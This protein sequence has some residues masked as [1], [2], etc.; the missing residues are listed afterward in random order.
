[1]TITESPTISPTTDATVTDVPVETPTPA[2]RPRRGSPAWIAVGAAVIAAGVL[3][4]NVIDS[5]PE[6]EPVLNHGVGDAKDHP[7]FGPAE[8]ATRV[9]ANLNRGVGDAK[10][11]P[12]NDD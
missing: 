9:V 5:G 6:P 8:P 4:V 11:N 7:R 10:D 1:M 2:R 12:N 3:A